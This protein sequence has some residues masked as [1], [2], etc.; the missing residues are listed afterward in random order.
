M[1]RRIRLSHC[2][3]AST[4][5]PLGGAVGLL[6]RP[7][8]CTWSSSALQ[9]IFWNGQKW[10]PTDPVN[11]LCL[12][13]ERRVLKH[14]GSDRVFDNVHR[15][16]DRNY[17]NEEKKYKLEDNMSTKSWIRCF[18]CTEKKNSK[19]CCNDT[20]LKNLSQSFMSFLELFLSSQ[21]RVWSSSLQKKWWFTINYWLKTWQEL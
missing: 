13:L 4:S 6:S 3:W 14:G 12:E 2:Y 20:L 7:V 21:F 15:N 8:L 18:P 1:F 10:F 16:E 5:C 17:L 19:T 9:R 11:S